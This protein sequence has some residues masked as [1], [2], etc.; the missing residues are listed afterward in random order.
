MS[1][2]L[3]PWLLALAL[4]LGPAGQWK[5]EEAGGGLRV[6]GESVQL[7]CRGSG[8]S[9]GNY[10]VWWYRQ[11]PRGSFEWVSFIDNSGRGQHN[12]AAVQDRATASRINSRSEAYLSLR[13]LEPRDSAQYF[14][15]VHTGTG[16]SVE[17]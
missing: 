2:G 3:G 4:A 6:P 8:F 7:S 13:A 15:A 1:A 5:L 9:F 17:L 12:R 11:S 16:N 10:Y 14:C